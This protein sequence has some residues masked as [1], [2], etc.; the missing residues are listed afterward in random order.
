LGRR[1]RF[2]GFDVRLVESVAEAAVVA[3]NEQRRLVPEIHGNIWVL[4]G[5]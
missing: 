5:V 2:L 3:E 1:L 4:Y